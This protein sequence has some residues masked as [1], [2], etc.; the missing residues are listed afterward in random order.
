ML[1]LIVNHML[2]RI[3]PLTSTKEF[4][5]V[6]QLNQYCICMRH[7]SFILHLLH[8]ENKK[9]LGINILCSISNSFSYSTPSIY[10]FW[11]RV[12]STLRWY[13][14]NMH[15]GGHANSEEGKYGSFIQSLKIRILLPLLHNILV[16]CYTSTVTL[17][18]I[19]ILKWIKPFTQSYGLLQTNCRI[20]LSGLLCCCYYSHEMYLILL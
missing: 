17:A 2:R 14:I 3:Y 4:C 5:C 8:K 11:W 19:I 15:N 7:I 16:T 1:N 13:L 6:Y 9:C 18:M 10:L 12:A 20:C